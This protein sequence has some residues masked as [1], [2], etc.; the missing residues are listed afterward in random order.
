MTKSLLTARYYLEII[1]LP[2]FIFLVV[3]LS[4]HGLMSLVEGDEHNHENTHSHEHHEGF[5][6]HGII[7]SIFT[8]EVLGGILLMILF[9]GI[10]NLSIFKKWVPCAHDH[11]H[12]KLKASHLFAIMAFCLHFFPEASIR[13]I[14]LQNAIAGE[15]TSIAGAIA[16]LAHFLVDIIV[17]I[18]LSSYWSNKKEF[19]ICLGF[20][21]TCWFI[22]LW[23]GQHIAENIPASAE[24]VLFLTSAFLLSMFIHKPHKPKH[25]THC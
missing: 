5:C 3:H 6:L 11:C 7:D 9:V 2:A 4:G 16:F 10:W 22:A 13:Y 14:L 19:T 18:L 25:C 24:V 17:A 21:I 8:L 20:I 1:A 12:N 15:I 23:G